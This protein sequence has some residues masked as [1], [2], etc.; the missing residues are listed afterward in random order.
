MI[1]INLDKARE[2]HKNKMREARAPK[3]A[4]L[5]IAFQRAQES[6]ADTKPIVAQKQ[7]LRDVTIDPAIAAASDVNALKAAWP[8]ILGDSPY[9]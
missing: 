5:D 9:A 7:A 8:A 4:A 1:T 2:I 6:G 3:L